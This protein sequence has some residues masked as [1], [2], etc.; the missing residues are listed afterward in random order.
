MHSQGKINDEE[1]NAA[2]EKVKAG[3]TFTKGSVSN[4]NNLLSYHAT[5][6]INQ[7]ANELSAKE[8][9]SYSEAREIVINSGYTIYTTVNGDIQTKLEEIYKNS[10]Y[11]IKGWSG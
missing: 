11:Q 7:V 8:D 3:L 2:N 9:I 5:A 1:Y 4:G 10:A 6:A